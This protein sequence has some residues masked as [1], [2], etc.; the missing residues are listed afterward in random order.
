MSAAALARVHRPEW[1]LLAGG[2]LASFIIGATMPAF[3]FL[4]SKLYGVSALLELGVTGCL[5]HVQDEFQNKRCRLQ[6]FAL[7][8]GAEVV[9]AAQLYAALFAGVAALCGLVTFLQAW[10]FNLAGTR[11]T[12][13]L[14]EMTFRNFLNQVRVTFTF[15]GL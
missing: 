14:R 7:P 12:D 5:D 15:P 9:S 10:L 13:R 2:G 1:G 11:L 6:M 4:F 3:A 8:D